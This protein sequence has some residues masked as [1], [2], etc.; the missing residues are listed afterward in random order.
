MSAST[1]NKSNHIFINGK[2]QI[3]E[4]LKLMP[5]KEKKKLLDNIRKRDA[6]LANELL[7]QSLTF[8]HIENLDDDVLK[9]I[10]LSTQAPILGLAIKYLST[11]FQ[12]RILSLANRE[13]AENAYAILVTSVSS[14]SDKVKKAQNKIL[15]QMITVMKRMQSN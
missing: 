12:R 11:E 5:A 14:E 10:I 15:M 2:N 6:V 13:Y 1:E 7:E 8:R 9:R 3:I 4:M